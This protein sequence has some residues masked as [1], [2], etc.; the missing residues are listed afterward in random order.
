MKYFIVK[1]ANDAYVGADGERVIRSLAA[2]FDQDTVMDSM[3]M[4]NGIAI[5]PSPVNSHPSIAQAMKVLTAEMQDTELG[6]YA[7]SWHCNLAM[8]FYDELCSTGISHK[9][10][11]K[12]ANNGA[13]RFMKLCFGV[14]TSNEPQAPARKEKKYERPHHILT[15]HHANETYAAKVSKCSTTGS[16]GKM[17]YVSVVMVGKP[18]IHFELPLGDLGSPVTS[19]DGRY[20]LARSS[21]KN[22]D[23]FDHLIAD[24]FRELCKEL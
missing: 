4:Y 13:T 12:I 20:I 1:L 22:H 17:L 5:E 8:S 10:A 21:G 2:R 18:E 6:S 19:T 23:V 9:A 24:A 11:H 14:S 3:L 16:A 15:I 7:H